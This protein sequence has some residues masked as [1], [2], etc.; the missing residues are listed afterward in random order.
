[1]RDNFQRFEK[2]GVS[3]FGINPASVEAH[4][5]YVDKFGFPFGILCD[6][7]KAVASAFGALK[8]SGGIARSVFAV[9]GGEV[10]FAKEGMPPTGEILA[11][12]AAL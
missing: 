5:Q 9:R 12:L 3:V 1:M 11:E 2:A 6:A 8:D 10:R 4:D 7:D